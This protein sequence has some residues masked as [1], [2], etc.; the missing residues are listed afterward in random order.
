[1]L[2]ESRVCRAAEWVAQRGNSTQGW[3]KSHT[4]D[5]IPGVS[6]QDYPVIA[7]YG[8]LKFLFTDQE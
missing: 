6:H 2:K 3:S 7:Y 5:F 1:M 8:T 4:I